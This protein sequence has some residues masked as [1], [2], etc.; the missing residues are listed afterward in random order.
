MAHTAPQGY[1]D[2][3]I[4]CIPQVLIYT[5]YNCSLH[6][7]VH[8]VLRKCYSELLGIAHKRTHTQTTA[9]GMAEKLT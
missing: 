6:I 8:I 2:D 9:Y 4:H 3:D 5:K 1:P 7:H